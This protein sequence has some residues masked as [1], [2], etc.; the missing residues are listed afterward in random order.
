[1]SPLIINLKHLYP[2]YDTIHRL[3]GFWEVIMNKKTKL[4]L[5]S[6]FLGSG[7]TTFLKKVLT[8]IEGKKIGVIQNEFGKISID[9]PVVEKQGVSVVELNRGSVFCS[10]LK[11]TFVEALV[12][13]LDRE[14]DYVF[15]ES[16]GLADPSNIGEILEGVEIVHDDGYDYAGAICLVDALHF[17]DQKKELEMLERQVYYSNITIVNKS[18]LVD[19]TTLKA[20]KESVMEIHPKV[21]LFETSFGNIPFD[22]LERNIIEG[23]EPVGQATTNTKENK[24]K[25]LSLSWEGTASKEKIATFL[26]SVAPQAYRIKGFGNLEEG[27]HKIDVVN[28]KID[29]V[30]VEYK[31]TSSTLVFIS[32]VGVQIIR[33]ID[34]AWKSEVG[35]PMKMKN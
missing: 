33:S 16:S 34:T 8:E 11:L 26:E 25:T 10:C 3:K 35:L 5:L 22:F 29:M 30:P 23:H 6:G 4:Y 28:Q 20:I 18:D 19:E 17:L 7:K 9:G 27:A 15:V 31:E 13:M 32:K 12:E 1:M 2:I 21:E 24:P 14:L